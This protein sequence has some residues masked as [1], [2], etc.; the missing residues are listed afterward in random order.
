VNQTPT[1]TGKKPANPPPRTEDFDELERRMVDVLVDSIKYIATTAGITIAVYSQILQDFMKSPAIQAS[2]TAKLLLFLPLLLWL[3][4]IIG[5]VLGIYPRS[6][7]ASTDLEKQLAIEK[8]R[9]NK[10]M[11]LKGVLALFVSAFVVFSYVIAAQIW[12][13]Y[14]F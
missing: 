14:P 8:I 6:Y 2:A 10:S 1:L 11:Y 4:T 7:K 5:T 3:L 12:G 13:V 9:S